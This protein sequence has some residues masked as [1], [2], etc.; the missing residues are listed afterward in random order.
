MYSI[1]AKYPYIYISILEMVLQLGL[2]LIYL[3]TNR[4][5]L[6]LIFFVSTDAK[7][8]K[9]EI[10]RQPGGP[11]SPP[12]GGSLSPS[13][14]LPPLDLDRSHH[15]Q[16]APSDNVSPRSTE[17]CRVSSPM[18]SPSPASSPRSMDTRSPHESIGGAAMVMREERCSSADRRSPNDLSH[19]ESLAIS[20]SAGSPSGGS[21]KRSSEEQRTSSSSSSGGS[22][23]PVEVLARLFPS[24]RRSVMQSVLQGCDGDVVQAIEQM[25]TTQKE[26]AAAAAAAAAHVGVSNAHL[27]AS[28]VAATCSFPSSVTDSHGAYITHRPYLPGSAAAAAASQL[29]NTG[30]KSAFS[31]LSTNDPRTI[32]AGAVSTANMPH[33]RFAY[34]PYPRGL[35]GGLA[36]W[37]PYPPTVIPAA[38]GMRPTG[39]GGYTFSG[40]MRDL[41]TGHKDGRPNGTFPV[42]N[43][44]E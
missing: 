12:L 20:A 36:L 1:P 4:L 29:N 8:P 28:T 30:M 10:F 14:P 43:A 44:V 16:S 11:T 27:V 2:Q 19:A 35:P 41:S 32:P 15:G 23:G 25:M 37:N 13:H 31:P 34:P 21:R 6:V 5:V 17:G 33:M 40:L 24:Q 3:I 42:G 38:F 26:E 22:G 39:E 9:L 18:K 7:R